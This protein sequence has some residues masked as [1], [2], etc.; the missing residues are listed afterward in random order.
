ML[1]RVLEV[2]WAP[3]RPGIDDVWCLFPILVSLVLL[4]KWV[5]S[6]TLLSARWVASM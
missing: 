3:V 1:A 5:V 6:W 2:F 4:V